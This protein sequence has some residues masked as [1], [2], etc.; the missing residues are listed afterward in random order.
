VD[1]DRAHHTIRPVVV[2]F[3]PDFPRELRICSQS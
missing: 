3:A 1:D 2:K